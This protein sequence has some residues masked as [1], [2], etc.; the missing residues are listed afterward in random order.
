MAKRESCRHCGG[1]SVDMVMHEQNCVMAIS[2]AAEYAALISDICKLSPTG[3]LEIYEVERRVF[4]RLGY[5]V[6]YRGGGW[7]IRGGSAPNVW[8]TMSQILTDFGTAIHY[9][10]GSRRGNLDHPLENNWY[11]KEMCETTE[12][13]ILLMRG[14]K[15]AAWAVRLGKI[16]SNAVD[17][18]AITPAAALV[19]A[20]LRAHP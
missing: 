9:T 12:D 8:Q 20:W 19:A 10:I 6:K 4:E 11:V 17:A 16:N 13:N 3:G 18:T 5:E 14:G 15:I 7:E 2:E 1:G